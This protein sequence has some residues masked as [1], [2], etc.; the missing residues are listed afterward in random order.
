MRPASASRCGRMPGTD[1][2]PPTVADVVAALARRYPPAGAGRDG[3]TCGDPDAPVRRVLLAV[4]PVPQT[5]TEALDRGADLLVVR[6]PLLTRPVRSVAATSVAGRLVHRLVSGGIALHVLASAAGCAALADRLGLLD[7]RPLAPAGAAMD[8]VATSVPRADADHVIDAL[9]A[10]GAGGIG[11]YTRC[12]WTATGVG[13]FLP[14]P[15]TTPTVGA[16][17]RVQ[18]VEETRVEMV[19]PRARR[20]AVLAALRDAHPYQEPAFYVSELAGVPGGAGRIGRLPEPV[21]LPG[22]VCLVATRLGASASSLRSAGRRDHPIWTVAVRAGHGDEYLTDAAT[23][24]AD[25][26]LTG[27]LSRDAASSVG[28]GGPAVVAAGYWAT[29]RPG[30]EPAAAALSGD[31]AGMAVEVSERVTDPWTPA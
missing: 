30:L 14:G 17:G 11:G 10:A 27:E 23:A 8:L 7:T 21:T 19:L 29:E 25:A 12:A 22:L 18:A 2:P 31:F 4:E 1:R 6:R 24:G 9:A 16:L 20:A 13:T 15:G 28:W 26:Y 5:V 3:L